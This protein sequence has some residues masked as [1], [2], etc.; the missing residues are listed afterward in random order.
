MPRGDEQ[1][2]VDAFC[3]W[4]RSDGWTVD[5]EVAF[6]DVMAQK[7]GTTLIAEAKGV[8]SSPGLDVDTAYGHLLRR[9]TGVPHDSQRYALVVPVET[10][11]AALRVPQRIRAL[12]VLDV[13][14]VAQDGAVTLHTSVLPS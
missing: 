5:T 4:L 9:M 1:R 6:I 8:T 14:S 3:D 11:A 13:Y 7:D 2:V 10:L 12:L